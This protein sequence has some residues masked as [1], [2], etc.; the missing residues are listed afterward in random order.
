LNTCT[1]QKN[2]PHVTPVRDLYFVGHQSK[3]AGGVGAV[4][5]GA[6]D[7]YEKAVKLGM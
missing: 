4:I 1:G 6:R 3:N 7:A 5:L 2:P